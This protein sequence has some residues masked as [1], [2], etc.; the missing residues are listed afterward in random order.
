MTKGPA[1][2]WKPRDR[3]SRRAPLDPAIRPPTSPPEVDRI[4]DAEPVEKRRPLS[5]VPTRV[6]LRRLSRCRYELRSR[7]LPAE[8]MGVAACY[9]LE[10][11]TRLMDLRP[12]PPPESG[13]E[14]RAANGKR[15]RIQGWR[16]SGEA[17][18][19]TLSVTPGL[20]HRAFDA[21]VLMVFGHDFG[22][23]RAVIASTEPLLRRAR[24]RTETNDWVVDS[25]GELWSAPDVQD[26]TAEF[27][28]LARELDPGASATP[29]H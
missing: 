25:D 28:S 3:A 23:S 27:R 4:A 10:L 11:A 29:A 13:Y 17:P 26:R 6:L 12:A 8:A 1:R 5:G 19:R 15:Y 18:P 14:A 7:G 22:I 9:A 16:V 24:Y 21:A 20:P 2:R